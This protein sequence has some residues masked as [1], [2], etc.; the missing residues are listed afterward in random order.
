MTLALA[1]VPLFALAA[2]GSPDP[3]EDAAADDAMMMDAAGAGAQYAVATLMDAD[4]NEVGMVTATGSGGGVTIDLMVSGMEPGTRGVH[5]HETGAC[6]PDFAAAGTHWNPEAMTHGLEGDDGQHAG[7]M[8]NLEVGEDGT[9]TLSYM[10]A[11]EASFEGL[12][13]DDGSAFV[14]HADED[15]QVTDP[16]GNSGD[17][18]ACGVFAAA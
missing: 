9:G 10:L 3:A 16:S 15:D 12:L 2:C 8:P 6:T 4:G 18:I 11:M 17:R 7:D 13:D 5:V 14:I 1:A